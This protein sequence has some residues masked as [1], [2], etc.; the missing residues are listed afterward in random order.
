MSPKKVDSRGQQGK[1]VKI[2][3]NTKFRFA[4]ENDTALILGFINDH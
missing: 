2:M 1:E 4:T 3:D